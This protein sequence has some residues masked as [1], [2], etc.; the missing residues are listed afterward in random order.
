MRP[1]AKQQLFLPNAMPCLTV[2]LAT[3]TD[4]SYLPK[5]QQFVNVLMSRYDHHRPSHHPA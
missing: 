4:T 2:A 1:Y 3:T 5:K